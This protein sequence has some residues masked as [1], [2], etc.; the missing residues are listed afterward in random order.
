MFDPGCVRLGLRWQDGCVRDMVLRV[1]RP[2]AAAVLRGRNADAAVRLLPLLYSICGAAQGVAAALDVVGERVEPA[3][4]RA[5]CS[6]PRDE[7]TL[8][9]RERQGRRDRVAQRP[10]LGEGGSGPGNAQRRILNTDV[11]R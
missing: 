10:D 2:A 4:D 11:R 9:W 1:E 8:T 5:G 3:L 7:G 6:Q